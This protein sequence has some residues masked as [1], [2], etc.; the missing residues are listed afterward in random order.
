MDCWP[1]SELGSYLIPNAKRG[2][3][4][5]HLAPILERLSIN[6]EGWVERM[7]D[8]GRRFHRVIGRAE[9]LAARAHACGRSWYQGQTAARLEFT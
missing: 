5:A 2:A 9:S 8:L 7:C 3:I 1:E 4:P 6:V